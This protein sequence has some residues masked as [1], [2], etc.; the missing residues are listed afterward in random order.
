MEGFEALAKPGVE[1][2]KA[3]RDAEAANDKAARSAQHSVLRKEKMPKPPPSLRDMRVAE[4]ETRELL[5]ENSV[6]TDKNAI[7][8]LKLVCTKYASHF[9]EKYP[10]IGKLAKPKESDDLEAWK[11][12]LVEMQTIIGSQRSEQRF[13]TMLGMGLTAI[14]NLNKTFPE[15]F[16]GHNLHYPIKLS[17]LATNPSFQEQIEDERNE[18]IFNHPNWFSSGH[19]TRLCESL[20][21]AAFAVAAKNQQE[22]LAAH[23]ETVRA[24][25]AKAQPK[26]EPGSA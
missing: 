17:S 6:F 3:R 16:G 9:K 23:Q 19:W 25:I 11:Q 8:K 24:S 5:K 10:E 13:N 4:K 2:A 12:Y 1:A 22:I 20:V 26:P 15:A 18:I 7:N 14:E 21:Q